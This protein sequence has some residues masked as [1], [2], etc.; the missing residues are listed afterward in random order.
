MDIFATIRAGDAPAA[1]RLLVAEPGLARTRHKGGPTPV[2]FALYHHYPELAE[3]LASVSGEL[4][5]AEAAALDRVDRVR[6]LLADGAA[7]DGRTPDGFTPLQLAA[8]FG[9]PATVELLIAAGAEV[10][11]VAANP[12]RIQPLHAAAAGQHPEVVR[13]LLRAGADPN[14]RQQGG[15]TPLHAAAQHGDTA[16]VELLLAAG[17]DPDATNDEGTTPAAAARQAGH[18]ELADRLAQR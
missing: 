4:D 2:L 11:A 6:E 5:L 12:M 9:A 10:D 7:V 18:P 17:T 16:L 13:I 1:T 3:A 15:W 8:Y 14:G